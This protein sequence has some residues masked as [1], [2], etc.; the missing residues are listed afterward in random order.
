MGSKPFT[1]TYRLI[2]V[3][4]GSLL[5][6]AI[7]CFAFIILW[8]IGLFLTKT[9][10]PAGTAFPAVLWLL[11]LALSTAA[12]T[13]LTRGGTVFPALFL[14]LLGSVLTCFF[15]E[16][17]VVT[18]GGVLLKIL[19]SLLVA[20]I[21]FTISKLIIRSTRYRRRSHGKRSGI[22]KHK[23]HKQD[24]VAPLMIQVEDEDLLGFEEHDSQRD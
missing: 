5:I 16:P 12:M 7:I 13:V 24:E 4:I 18:F 22:R 21:A 2:P 17:G 9:P 1:Q 8:S 23:K 6:F 19:L 20:V 14:A 11:A 3:L 15:A 10:D